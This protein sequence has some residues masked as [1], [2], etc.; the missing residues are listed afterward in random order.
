MNKSSKYLK[1]KKNKMLILPLLYVMGQNGLQV[2]IQCFI[3]A[4]LYLIYLYHSSVWVHFITMMP[5][6]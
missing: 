2:F 5:K 1:N 6:L 3:L 4:D